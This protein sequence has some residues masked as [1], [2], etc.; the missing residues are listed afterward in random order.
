MSKANRP[1]AAEAYV[2]SLSE[3][4]LAEIAAGFERMTGSSTTGTDAVLRE[5]AEALDK[6]LGIPAQSVLWSIHTL[7]LFVYRRL[8]RAE[9][10]RQGRLND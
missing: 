6:L 5:H 9:L 2:A 7:A 8:G 3:D 1:S 4:T 10:R